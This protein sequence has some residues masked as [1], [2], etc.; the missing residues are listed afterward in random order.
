M[1]LFDFY[2]T[3]AALSACFLI[4][5]CVALDGPAPSMDDHGPVAKKSDVGNPNPLFEIFK[6]AHTASLQA[7]GDGA[8]AMVM[9]KAGADFVNQNCDDYFISNGRTETY[10]LFGRDMT[11]LVGAVATTAETAAKASTGAIGGTAIATTSLVAGNDLYRKQLTGG[12]DFTASARS[13]VKNTLTA[14]ETTAEAKKTDDYTYGLAERDV[15][16]LQELCTPP[17]IAT[18]MAAAI[19]KHQF[20]AISVAS[21]GTTLPAAGAA[22]GAVVPGPAAAPAAQPSAA[23]QAK[24]ATTKQNLL[25]L[26]VHGLQLSPQTLASLDIIAGGNAVAPLP[27]PLAAALPA[28]TS[29]PANARV[30][31]SP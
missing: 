15:R 4:T 14:F 18:N 8:K 29:V 25:D 11:L 19:A 27:A 21:P 23:A 10:M 9:F 28:V 24:A 20:T 1:L 22:N 13:M 6:G 7:P 16:D 26:Q 31:I 12:A 2:K 17:A 30:V 5:G 3:I